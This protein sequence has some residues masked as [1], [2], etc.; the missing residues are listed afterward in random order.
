MP[1]SNLKKVNKR[2]GQGRG[3]RDGGITTT[4]RSYNFW[5]AVAGREEAGGQ[6]QKRTLMKSK[7]EIK[8]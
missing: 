6:L 4:K 1:K 7:R 5:Q 3:W 8:S 2:E